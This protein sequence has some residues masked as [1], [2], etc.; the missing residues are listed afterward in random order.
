M[1][2][3]DGSDVTE[4]LKATLWHNVGTLVTSEAQKLSNQHEMPISATPQFIG[5][6]TEMVWIQIEN[7][8]MDLEAFAR[9]AG[10]STI[11]TDDVLLLTRRNEELEGVLR[12][13]IE[14]EVRRKS[15]G[16]GKKTNS[17]GKGRV[18]KRK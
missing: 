9:H 2:N 13:W 17:K 8:A 7:V 16:A 18:D 1:T 3:V 6:L 11:G 14:A 12:E 15:E 10:R 4:R 5:A